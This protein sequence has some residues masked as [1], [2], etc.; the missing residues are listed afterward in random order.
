MTKPRVIYWFRTDLRLHDSPA[1]QA[2]LDLDPAVLWPVFTWDPHYV[3]RVRGGLNRWQFLLD[4]QNDLSKSIT[5]L[6][7]KSKLFVLREGPQTLFK[8]LFKAWKVTHLVFEKDTDVYGRERDAVVVKAAE[9]AGVKVVV[10]SGRTLWD[11]DEVVKKNNGKP[12]MSIAQLQHAGERVGDIPRP[13][14][15]PKSLPDPGEMPV[16]FEQ[17]EP[18]RQPDFNEPRREGKDTAYKDIAGPKGDFAIE[19]MEELGFPS[20]TTSIRGG[21]SLALKALGKIIED[22]KYTATFE[23][24]KT[25]PAQFE[26]QATTLLS[27]FLHFGA[28][29]VREFFWRVQD[30]VTEYGKGASSPPMSLTGQLY[31]RDMYFAAQAALGAPF[32]QTAT[33][34][35]VRFVPWHL[36]SKRDA[37]SGMVTGE[38]H[39]DSEEAEVWFKRWRNGV[40]GF[41]WIDA[42]MRQLKEEGWIHHLGRHSVA[43]FLTRGGCYVDWER[44]AEVFEEWL[45]D[46]EPACNAGNWQW[47]SCTAFFAQYYRCYSP[48]SFGQKWDKEGA[49]IRKYV[50]E[51]KDLD[52]KYIY[53]PWKAPIADQKKAGVRVQGD[54]L[55]DREKGTYPK[56]M[57]DFSER[58]NVCI[59][60]LKKAYAVGL[61]GNDAQVLNGTWRDLF[62][63]PDEAEV[64]NEY[65]S[66]DGEHADNAEQRTHDKGAQQAGRKRAGNESVPEAPPKKQSKRQ[67]TLNFRNK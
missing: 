49:L 44:G 3:Y 20:A 65:D 46:H 6:N 18:D 66:D 55:G 38:Y 52:K 27:P 61:H 4:C 1:L 32:H 16:D 58:R 23:K 29:S 62:P 45:L 56:P 15:A 22:K 5:K 17:D 39:V 60:G 37:T 7:P 13:I 41:P 2:A 21:E 26:P 24:P 59:S 54:G 53:E 50:P 43:C 34:P 9:E 67:Q 40:T 12:T 25:S 19:T 33:N 63:S 30:V 51:L 35:Y 42:L 48:I 64:M 28:L 8:K 47:L 36:P 57:F 11:S 10:R 31:F 14:A